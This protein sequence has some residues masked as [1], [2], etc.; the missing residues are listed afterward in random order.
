[1]TMHLT[2]YSVNKHADGYVKNLDTPAAEELAPSPT[3]T[4]STRY[5]SP[6]SE[7]EHG[8]EEDAEAE[9]ECE[10]AK[11]EGENHGAPGDS[12]VSSKW[13]LT[14]L[15]DYFAANGL[16]YELMMQRIKD[17]VIKTLISVEPQLVSICHQGCNS[18]QDAQ[19]SA[20]GFHRQITTA[21]RGF[22]HA[23]LSLAFKTQEY[24]A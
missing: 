23:C 9:G 22:S 24:I 1:R 7:E 16:N 20:G 11:E 6:H 2:N 15:R 4:A 10:E 13:S 12:P 21:M 17:L 8:E 19:A 5:T 3:P 14:Q 18:R